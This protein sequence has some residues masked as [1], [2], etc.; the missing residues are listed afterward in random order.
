[1]NSTK[2]ICYSALFLGLGLVLPFITGQIPQIG[3]ALL[4][5]H[6]PVLLCGLICGWQYGLM[7]GVICPLLRS[8][9]FGIPVMVPMAWAMA[10]ELGTYGLIS[11]L[12]YGL[13]RHKTL[14]SLYAAMISAM[15][16]GR[17]VYGLFMLAFFGLQ[18]QRY[19]LQMFLAATL[20]SSIPGIILQ[21]VLIPLLMLALKQTSLKE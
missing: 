7:V 20:T 17:L 10:F 6:I 21:L 18:S 14:P 2:K 9:L 15:L 5:M 19:T 3:Q 12:V 16:G 11:G 8:L 1:M 13:F 4:P